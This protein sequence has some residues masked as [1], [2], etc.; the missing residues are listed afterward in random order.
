[1]LSNDL[2]PWLVVY[3]QFR[4]WSDASCFEAL[5]SHMLSIIRVSQGQPSA[6]VPDGQTLQSSFDSRPRAGYDSYKRW[7][8]SKNGIELQ[9]FNP[10]HVKK[11]FVCCCTG[12]GLWSAALAAWPNS[13]G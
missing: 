10:H 6:V 12:V 5:V 7:K 3:Q 1:M 11:G 4:P 9:I 13:D 8:G 2:L